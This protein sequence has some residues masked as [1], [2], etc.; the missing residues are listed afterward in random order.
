MTIKGKGDMET[1]FLLGNNERTLPGQGTPEKTS[2]AHISTTLPGQ[3][4]TN[5]NGKVSNNTVAKAP[6][7]NFF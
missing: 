4:T 7:E 5:T 3:E 2:T 6:G 1:W